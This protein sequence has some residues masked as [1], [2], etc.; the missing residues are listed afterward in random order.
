MSKVKQI[1]KFKTETE[2]QEFWDTHDATEYIDWT[3]N[4]KLTF[5]NLKLSK[6]SRL[7]KSKY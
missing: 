2:E 5:P 4:K 6:S 1:P 7:P 3:K